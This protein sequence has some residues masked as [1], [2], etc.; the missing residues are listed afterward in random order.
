MKLNQDLR[1]YARSNLLFIWQVA[2]EMGISEQTLH[3]WLRNELTEEKRKKFINA[4][5]N[6]KVKNNV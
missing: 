6:L 1:D 3:T 2:K 4:V 5:D